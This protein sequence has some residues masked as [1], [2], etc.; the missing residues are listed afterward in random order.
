MFPV[1]LSLTQPGNGEKMAEQCNNG[2][3]VIFPLFFLHV[4]FKAK[5]SFR[6]EGLKIPSVP[7][8]LFRKESAEM[9]K[10]RQ[11]TREGHQ[12]KKGNKSPN[13]GMQEQQFRKMLSQEN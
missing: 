2:F 11:G 5:P 6:A 7:G 12:G 10:D 8:Q 9:Q 1:R 3:G 13:K 4:H